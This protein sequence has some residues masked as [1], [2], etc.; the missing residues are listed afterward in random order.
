MRRLGAVVDVDT[1]ELIFK[2]VFPGIRIP[3]VRG[4][5]GHLLLDLC[6]DWSTYTSVVPA[7]SA[8]TASERDEND[9]LRE[10]GAVHASRHF[11][12]QVVDEMSDTSHDSGNGLDVQGTDIHASGF[13]AQDVAHSSVR[14]QVCDGT[15]SG[16]NEAQLGPREPGV[17]CQDDGVGDLRE[18]GQDQQEG[19]GPVSFRLEQGGVCKSSTSEPWAGHAKDITKYKPSDEDLRAASTAPQW[20]CVAANVLFAFSTARQSDRRGLTAQRVR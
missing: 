18:E 19:S 20:G 9:R 11:E 1:G 14:C 3:L 5:N 4:K 2:R 8:L 15:F 10:S 12:V 13:T 7:S 17:H 16:D 6:K